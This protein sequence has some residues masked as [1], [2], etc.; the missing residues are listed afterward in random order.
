FLGAWGWLA[1]P[2]LRLADLVAVPSAFLVKVLASHGIVSQLLPNI[3][4]TECFMFRRRTQFAP[5]LLATRN[6][7]PMYNVECLLRSFRFVQQKFPT[8]V[9]GIVGMGSEESRLHQ[10]A[11]D[12]QLNVEF[13][14]AVRP[15]DMPE[16]YDRFDICVNA[17]NIDN[18]PGA[19]VEAAC[20]GLPIVTTAAGGIPEMLENGRT[21]FLVGLNDDRAIAEKVIQLIEHP[22][23]ALQIA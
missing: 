13:Y 1:L 18:F 21:G 12:W 10:L 20:C 19:L 4:D 23:L 15:Q 5:R 8:A 9:L 7:E 11:S 2:I 16:L 6:L 22:D 3:A 14:G 17:S